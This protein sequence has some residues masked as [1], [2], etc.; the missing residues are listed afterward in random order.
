MSLHPR[1]HS[2][3]LHTNKTQASQSSSTCLPPQQTPTE[4]I[5][6]IPVFS[7]QHARDFQES[8]TV[9]NTVY[10]TLS[11]KEWKKSGKQNAS[12]PGSFFGSLQA[13]RIWTIHIQL[14]LQILPEWYDS[15]HLAHGIPEYSCSKFVFVYLHLH[16]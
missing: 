14:F 15:L 6:T 2:T 8:D 10:L 9:K 16:I 11:A 12:P 1:G 7:R 4:H 5:T 13:R 3:D